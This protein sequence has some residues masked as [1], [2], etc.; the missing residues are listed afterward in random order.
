MKKLLVA[1]AA[2]ATLLFVSCNKESQYPTLI[3]GTWEVKSGSAAITKNGKPVTVD[4][5]ITDMAALE[6]Q[7]VEIPESIKQELQKAF[8]E[9]SK[10]QT[11]PEGATLTFKE[12]KVSTTEGI[13]GS[14]YTISG[15][16]LTLNIDGDSVPFTIETLTATD[17]VLSTDSSNIPTTTQGDMFKRAGYVMT[18]TITFKKK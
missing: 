16:T 14:T 6:G 2:L 3:E 7:T 10:P 11:F 18:M 4:T 17:L 12:G 1:V 8:D 15:N 13:G 9:M 5:F